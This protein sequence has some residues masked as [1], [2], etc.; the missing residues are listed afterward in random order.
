MRT[1]MLIAAS[2]AIATPALADDSDAAFKKQVEALVKTYMDAFNSKNADGVLATYAPDGFFLAADGHTDKGDAMRKN[3]EG[4]FAAGLHDE[5]TVTEAHRYGNAGF[6]FGTFT[7]TGKNMSGGGNWNATYV[8]E[9][10]QPRIKLLAA[11]VPPPPP[12]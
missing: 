12:K 6:A 4:A 3:L 2:F 10:D 9:G 1:L 11:S 7:F 5:A 8:I